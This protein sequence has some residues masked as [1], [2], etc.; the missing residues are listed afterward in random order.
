VLGPLFS[1]GSAS[2]ERTATSAPEAAPKVNAPALRAKERPTKATQP[3]AADDKTPGSNESG[4]RSERDGVIRKVPNFP[5][6]VV[7][8]Q[9]KS[10]GSIQDGLRPGHRVSVVGRQGHWLQIE[11]EN[12][13]GKTVRGWTHEVNVTVP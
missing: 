1:G 5:S 10:K 2:S 3:A 13:T 7:R 11:Y 12:R 8:Y 4:Q 9:P 6:A